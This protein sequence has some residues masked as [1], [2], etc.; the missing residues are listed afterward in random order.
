MDSSLIKEI[1][2]ET[3]TPVYIYREEGIVDNYRAFYSAFREGCA[4][5]R[6]FYAY[7]ANTNLALC[8]ILA[9]EGAG[10]DVVSGGELETALKAGLSGRDIIFTSNSKTAAE[11]SLAVDCGAVIN[12]DSQS[13]L[14]MLSDIAREKGKTARISFRINPGIDA[15]THDK[16]ATGLK[17]SKFGIHVEEGLALKAYKTAKEMPGLDIAGVH[18]HLGSQIRDTLP[19][20]SAAEKIFEFTGVLKK[21]L[22][23]ELGFVDLGGG[24]AV[25]YE[26]EKTAPPGDLADAIV[27]V[28]DRWCKALGYEPELWLEPGRYLVAGAGMLLCRVQSVKETPYKRFVNLDAGFNTFLRPAMYDAYHK[29]NVVGRED[30]KPSVKYDVAGNICESGDLFARDRML[31]ET[32]EGDL[33]AI[34]DAGAYG[35]SMASR[36]NSRPLP[37]EVLVRSDGSYEVI[38]ERESMEDLYRNQRIPKDLL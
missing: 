8:R 32:R 6:V 21:E 31:P 19:Y 38:R 5:S 9:R 13:E 18:T 22:G 34:L 3:G 16:I 4:K 20:A 14:S 25:P 28:Y 29:I 15:K 2:R 11:L 33:M 27:P 35:Y 17:G 30:D 1:A 23:I 7:K 37:P 24:L 36:Y 12:V 26:G 10:A